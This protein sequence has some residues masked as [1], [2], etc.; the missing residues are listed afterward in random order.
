KQAEV[1]AVGRRFSATRLRPPHSLKHGPDRAFRLRTLLSIPCPQRHI[2]V[3]PL[4]RTDGRS[5]R[6]PPPGWPWRLRRASSAYRLRAHRARTISENMQTPTLS[7]GATSSSIACRGHAFHHDYIA[8]PEA[9]R[10]ERRLH[11]GISDG[12]RYP[13]QGSAGG[14]R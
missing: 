6:S 11:C 5:S 1:T 7:L 13:S 3:G 2:R 4:L 8:D 10:P 14:R 12:G 9:R